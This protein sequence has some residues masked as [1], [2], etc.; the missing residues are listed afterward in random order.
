MRTKTKHKLL[1]TWQDGRWQ[2]ERFVGLWGGWLVGWWV[3]WLVGRLSRKHLFLL[4]VGWA[5]R[6]AQHCN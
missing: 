2:V 4:S 3:G 1:V 5:A 6:P